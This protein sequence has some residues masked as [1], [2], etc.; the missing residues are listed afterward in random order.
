MKKIKLI[1]DFK[2]LESK[3]TAEHFQIHLLEFLKNNQILNYNSKVELVNEHHSINF[4]IIDEEYINL[5]KNA[6]KP[7]KAFL[8]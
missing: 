8:V 1:W 3:K 4:L 5:I 6:L 2:G 7:H